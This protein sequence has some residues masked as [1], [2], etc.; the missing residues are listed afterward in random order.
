MREEYTLPFDPDYK[1]SPGEIL[2]EALTHRGMSGVDFAL[3]AGLEVVVVDQILRGQRPLTA[4]VALIVARTLD[5]SPHFWSELAKKAPSPGREE[6]SEGS[7]RGGDS[8]GGS[9]SDPP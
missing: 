5:E 1:I 8:R 3:A 9:R 2:Q 7:A 4:E 6:G